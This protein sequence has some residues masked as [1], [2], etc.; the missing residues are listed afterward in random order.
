MKIQAGFVSGSM[1][2]I[3]VNGQYRLREHDYKSLIQWTELFDEVVFYFTQ[4]PYDKEKDSWAIMDEKKCTFVS[5]CNHNDSISVKKQKIKSIVKNSQDCDIYYYRLP[6]YEPMFFHYYQNKK[7]PY[8][9]ELHGDHE[10]AIMSGPQAWLR[11]YPLSKLLYF[12]TKKMGKGSSFA[13]SIGEVLV[14]KYVPANVPQYVTTNHLTSVSEYPEKCLYHELSTPIEILFVGAVQ[15]RKGLIYL[16]KALQ[17]M[18]QEGIEFRMNIV[19]TGEQI[20]SL[21]QFAEHEGFIQKVKLWGQVTHGEKLYDIYRKCD[22]F[23][24]PSV[25]A[26]GVPRVTH[27]AM[28]FGCPVVATDIGSVKWQLSG[29]TGIVV[30][31]ANVDALY[32]AI[33]RVSNNQEVR[34]KLIYL[35]YEKSKVYSWEAQKDGNN[36]FA[37]EQLVKIFKK[38]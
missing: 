2:C 21:V 8:F 18:H 6:S 29:G 31:S 32:N 20:K 11:K 37:K 14:K 13:Y 23:V 28:I 33:M 1:Y 17:K 22:L 9:I 12:Y 27:E 3:D 35:G 38:K 10:T 5:I 25:A 15:E 34:K 30:E 4:V 36:N 19:G 26:E 16:F 24:L 7:I